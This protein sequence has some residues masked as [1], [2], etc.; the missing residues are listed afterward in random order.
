MAA[1]FD[2][3]PACFAGVQ[4]L[5]VP[6]VERIVREKLDRFA[7]VTGRQPTFP[8][9][10]EEMVEI[11]EKIV[12]DYFDDSHPD[13]DADVLGAYDFTNDKLF[14]RQEIEHE[15][16]RRFTWAHEYGHVVLHRPHFMQGVL[17]FFDSSHNRVVQLHRGDDRATNKLEWQANAFASHM[18]MPTALVRMFLSGR[19]ALDD[20][21]AYELADAAQVSLQAARIRLRQFSP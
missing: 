1:E 21:V 6:K 8:I 12:V 13:F 20:K 9:D 14:I 17:E 11:M 4:F 2:P 10:I 3:V 16:R 5:P 19:T 7:R 15:G 18:L